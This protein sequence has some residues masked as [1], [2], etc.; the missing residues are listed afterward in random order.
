MYLLHSYL[1]WQTCRYYLLRMK[2]ATQKLNQTLTKMSFLSEAS[3]I[4]SI[5]SK[6]TR[7]YKILWTTK[8][9]KI[10]GQSSGHGRQ[11]IDERSWVRFPLLNSG[12]RNPPI[13]TL[14]YLFT[15]MIASLY[16]SFPLSA[17]IS[18]LSHI[19]PKSYL[20]HI[21]PKSYHT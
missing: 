21:I 19:I 5:N 20:S 11:R 14:Y 4:G 16:A 10:W 6:P 13:A 12:P 17:T 15:K 3:R 8:W 2:R 18:Y 9:K 1:M 7:I